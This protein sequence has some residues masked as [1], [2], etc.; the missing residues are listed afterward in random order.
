M[1]VPGSEQ[2]R[3]DRALY[4]AGYTKEHDGDRVHRGDS[5]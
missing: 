3:Q 1:P 5:E 2:N 4:K